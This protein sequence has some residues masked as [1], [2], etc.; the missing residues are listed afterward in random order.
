M[1]WGATQVFSHHY[2]LPLLFRCCDVDSFLMSLW[3][4]RPCLSWTS[5]TKWLGNTRGLWQ[6]RE[7]FFLV[8]IYLITLSNTCSRISLPFF[9]QKQ[10]IL[11]V[12]KITANRFI[13]LLWDLCVY[14]ILSYHLR[15]QECFSN[16][17]STSYPY[18]GTPVSPWCHQKLLNILAGTSGRLNSKQ[19]SRKGTRGKRGRGK[20]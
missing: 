7:I 1:I 19:L 9:L 20:K 16:L 17:K 15:V 14:Q 5:D 18:T 8:L 2:L 13:F 10:Y 3:R 4:R 11:V 12:E 6:T